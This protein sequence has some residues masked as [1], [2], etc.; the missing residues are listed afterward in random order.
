MY[1]LCC[2]GL[3][4]HALYILALFV[5]SWCVVIACHECYS[6]LPTLVSFVFIVLWLCQAEETSHRNVT[7]FYHLGKFCI[8]CGCG[9]VKQRKHHIAMLQ[10]FTT[11]VSFVFIVVVVVSSRGNITSQCYSVLLPWLVLYLLWCG[12]V[13][14]RKHNIA[15]SQCFTHFGQFCIYCGV[16]VSSRG[17]ITL[18]CYSVLPPW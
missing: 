15:M 11:L 1:G 16:V 17:N 10:C 3:S 13:K 12:C 2:I 4:E 6:V 5:M 8:Y 14:Q 18:Q 9:C 7:V